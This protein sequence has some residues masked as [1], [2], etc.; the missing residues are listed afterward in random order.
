MEFVWIEPGFFAMG[1]PESETGRAPDEGPQHQVTVTNGFYLGKFEVT[2][3][4]WEAVIGT[5]PW[6]GQEDVRADPSSPAVYITRND[7]EAF[8]R[9]L[10]L[11]TGAETYRLP[12]EAEWEYA[13]RAGTTT[14]WSFG[15]DESQAGA[16]A[17]FAYNTCGVGECYAHGVGSKKANPWGLYDMHGNV[18]EYC[19]DWWY[20]Y[21]AE[22]RTD[23][24]G[25]SNGTICAIRGG[26]IKGVASSIRSAERGG[27]L[28]SY[29]NYGWGV[30]LVMT[31]TS[32]PLNRVPVSSAGPDQAV[33]LGALV[34]LDGTGSQD[35]DGDPLTYRW[36]APAGVTLSDATTAN[37]TFPASAVGTFQFLLFV[38][39]GSATSADD[40]VAITVEPKALTADLP[41]GAAMEFVWVEPGTFTM[42][43]PD[44]EVPHEVTISKG[45][46]IGQCEITQGQWAAVTGSHPW[47]RYLQVPPDTDAPAIWVAWNDV[48]SLVHQLNQAAGDSLYRLP[49]EAEWEYACRAGTSTSW[50][51][52]DEESLLKEYAWYQG[53]T[54]GEEYPHPVQTKK[55]NPW[56]LYD[57]HGNVWEWVQDRYALFPG[58]NQVDPTGSTTGERR[59]MR[60]GAYGYPASDVTSWFRGADLPDVGGGTL[61]AR[62]VRLAEPVRLNRPPAGNAG[63]DQTVTGGA[64]VTLDGGGSSD[65]DGDRLAYGW[66]A[67]AGIALSSAGAAR[68]TFTAPTAGTYRFV[69]VVNDSYADSAPDTVV[70]TVQQPPGPG[71]TMKA[72]LP[73]GV[74]ME[75]V[76]IEPGA[77]TMGS[78]PTEPA[79]SLTEQPSHEVTISNGF[80]LG[81]YEVTQRQWQAVMGTT[82]WV[83]QGI[84]V[85]NPDHPAAFISW[86]DVQA[87]V[88]ELNHAAADSLY[89]LPTEA[90]WEYACRAGTTTRWSF[91]D[92]AIQ[93]G[94]YAW[95]FDNTWS[96]GE[97]YGHAVGSKRPNP[98][99]LY[100]THG[101]AYEWVQDWF[102]GYAST[103]S[104]QVDPAGPVWGSS[105][106]CR[107]GEFS[108]GAV[109]TRS[110][111]RAPFA[112]SNRFNPYGVRLL[113]IR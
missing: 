50:S 94:Q 52:G 69:L 22:A 67:P 104:L 98:W 44:G 83:G 89:R 93:L 57:M 59:V 6:S 13:C 10:N 54:G 80:Y 16:Y 28:P 73:N 9:E 21:T 74:A 20:T 65:P 17:W 49:T 68:P 51:F 27:G 72:D 1:S 75:F 70:V 101:N 64:S 29:R 46:Y 60:G 45:Y 39:D 32:R 108:S 24:T 33:Q 34:Q 41:G 76:W 48:Q 43:A 92:D 56:G 105:R 25:P 37:P 112:P 106:V 31:A 4:Q 81:R 15:D 96:V 23:P 97:A 18:A 79:P 103:S 82:P 63:V 11:A 91:G 110:A 87:L 58:G 14:R 88:Q 90:E 95:Y 5:A 84:A 66:A 109:G 42:G 3:A 35:P 2:Q 77:F 8:V 26:D 40:T 78:P 99:G 12:T 61:G 86:D 100:D 47:E 19:Q 85:V 30:R 38:N 7:V 62:L 71:S 111:S 53:N 113:R 102:G 36:W 107:G 55:P